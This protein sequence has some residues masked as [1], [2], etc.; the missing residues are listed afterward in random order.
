MIQVETSRSVSLRL[1]G[2]IILATILSSCSFPGIV[3]SGISDMGTALSV[4]EEVSLKFFTNDANFDSGIGLQSGAR[5]ALEVKTLSYLIDSSIED[6][7]D[8]E[9]LD[10]HGF[11]DAR[12]AR[13]LDKGIIPLSLARLSKRSK[14]HRWFELM[15]YNCTRDSLRGVSDLS[16]DEEA[17]FIPSSQHVTAS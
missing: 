7:E 9:P 11:S 8:G 4:G 17:E 16:V 13:Q 1:F 5:Y 6:N 15:Q 10:E 3:L 2:V 14:Q 12:M